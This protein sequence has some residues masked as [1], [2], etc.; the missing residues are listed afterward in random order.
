MYYGLALISVLPYSWYVTDE[1]KWQAVIKRDRTYDGQFVFAVTSTRI[2]CRPS[3]PSRRPRRENVR[4]FDDPAIAAR[5]GFRECRRCGGRT[6]VDRVK[7]VLDA[8]VDS[9]IT[10]NALAHRVGSTPHHVQRTFR[11]RT[12]V[13]PREY[14]A[15]KRAEHFKREL[16]SGRDVTSATYESG[17]GSSSRLYSESDARLG[18]TPATYRRG[19]EGMSIHFATSRTSL[20]VILVATTSRG[21]CAVSLGNSAQI[22]EEALRNEFPRADIMRSDDAAIRAVIEDVEHGTASAAGLPLDLRA[23]AFQIRVWNEL[24]KIPRG[25]T[26]TYG[27]IAQSIGQPTAA[28]AVARACATNRVAVVVPCHRVIRNDGELGGYRWGT[29]RKKKLLARERT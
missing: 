24:R 25:E 17:Y 16:R 11:A 14:L 3:C 21:I 5:S 26:R 4:F 9:G 15:A 10:L 1:T 2:Y 7:D 28:R 6:L 12:G 20:G 8:H 29:T 18:M 22:L 23:T 13:S 19:G 27:E